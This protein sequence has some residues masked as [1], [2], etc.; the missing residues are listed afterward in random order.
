M[1]SINHMILYSV[2]IYNGLKEKRKENYIVMVKQ[3]L[4]E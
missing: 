4:Y 2:D 1:V 3:K